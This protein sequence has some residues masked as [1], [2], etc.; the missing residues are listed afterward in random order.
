[1]SDGPTQ[2]DWDKHLI[3]NWYVGKFRTMKELEA[4][5][6]KVWGVFPSAAGFSRTAI[7]SVQVWKFMES[8]PTVLKALNRYPAAKAEEIAQKMHDLG[9]KSR[10]NAPQLRSSREYQENSAVKASLAWNFIE[11]RKAKSQNRGEQWNVC[12]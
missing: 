6:M 12:K 2:L 3:R 11:A 5:F 4:D 1:M 9:I 10:F 7:S 8:M